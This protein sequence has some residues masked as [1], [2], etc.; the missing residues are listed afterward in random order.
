MDGQVDGSFVRISGRGL[1]TLRL[2]RPATSM[3]R[4]KEA[5]KK[6]TTEL[7]LPI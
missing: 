5:W 1:L 4:D 7:D 3:K 6:L 2:G